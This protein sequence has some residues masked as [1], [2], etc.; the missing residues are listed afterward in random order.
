MRNRAGQ[1]LRERRLELGLTQ[2]EVALELHM[3]I[4]QFQRSD[5]GSILR[6]N[7]SAQTWINLLLY[8][9]MVLPLWQI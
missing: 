6:Q 1:I 5:D 3:S 4:R 9:N 2:E 8:A 7:T